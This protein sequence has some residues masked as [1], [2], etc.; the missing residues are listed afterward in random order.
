MDEE[1]SGGAFADVEAFLVQVPE[2]RI[3]ASADGLAVAFDTPPAAPDVAAA[4]TSFPCACHLVCLEGREERGVHWEPPSSAQKQMH[5]CWEYL[6][7]RDRLGT[8]GSPSC[9][10][11]HTVAYKLKAHLFLT[12]ENPLMTAPLPS[13]SDTA[14]ARH[15]DVTIDVIVKL[16]EM[17][18]EEE[19]NDDADW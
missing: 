12:A 14:G 3:T 19:G 17:W 18:S 15:S 2:A 8:C 13:A 10:L 16:K 9:L 7:V 4:V 5:A 1:I 11:L 6:Q